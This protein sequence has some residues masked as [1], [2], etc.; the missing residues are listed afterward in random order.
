MTDERFKQ[1]ILNPLN[2]V[3]LILKRYKDAKDD[4]GFKDWVS[5]INKI[6]KKD[7]PCG[8]NEALYRVLLSCGD[9][10]SKINRGEL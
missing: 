8:Y 10:I 7:L 6:L 3:Y 9:I 4:E 2:E 1:E 5:D